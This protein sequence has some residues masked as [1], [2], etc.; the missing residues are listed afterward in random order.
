MAE[1]V[2]EDIRKYLLCESDLEKYLSGH[3]SVNLQNDKKRLFAYL[4]SRYLSAE[5]VR[6]KLLVSSLVRRHL[7][8]FSLEVSS[9][10]KGVVVEFGQKEGVDIF[11]AYLDDQAAWYDSKKKQMLEAELGGNGKHLISELF[12]AADNISKVAQPTANIPPSP[13]PGY[14]L[15]CLLD[16]KGIAFGLGDS[17]DMATDSLGGPLIRATLTLRELIINAS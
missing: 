14:I 11:A 16:S 13:P 12:S 2:Q 9:E 7:V 8:G 17:R 4:E 6:D 5:S 15:I 1:I 10:V 3:G